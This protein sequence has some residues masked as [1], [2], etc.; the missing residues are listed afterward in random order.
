[1]LVLCCGVW[2]V[3]PGECVAVVPVETELKGFLRAGHW[4]SLFT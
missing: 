2:F 4:G 3:D 1:M